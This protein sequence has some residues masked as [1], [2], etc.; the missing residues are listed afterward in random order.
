MRTALY[1]HF[2]SDEALLYVGISLSWLSRTKAHSR[3]AAWFEQI[4]RVSIEWFETREA[5]LDAERVA[6]KNERPK[7]N[8]IHNRE[9]PASKKRV[10]LPAVPDVSDEACRFMGS[11]ERRRLRNS[12][13]PLLRIVK[14]PDALV[15]PALIY[16]DDTI[17]VMIAHG[18]KGGQSELTEVVLGA[19][20]PSTPP[21]WTDVCSTVLVIRR[22]N[23]LTMEEAQGLRITVIDRLKSAL[24]SVSSFNTDY[25]LAEANVAWFPSAASRRIF[26][27]VAADRGAA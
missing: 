9:P 6:I 25:A 5:A 2:S 14:G 11:S 10:W 3:S 4:A 26:N 20:A 27:E 13:D 7:F 12:G 19:Y 23:D 21:A 24:R 8:V 22:A 1:R 18:S 17:S 16:R 15:G